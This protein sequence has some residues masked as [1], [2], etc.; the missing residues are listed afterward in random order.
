MQR[1]GEEAAL[2]DLRAAAAARRRREAAAVGGGGNSGG[3][4]QQQRTRL[5]QPP[6]RQG[7]H[8]AILDAE[9][10][11]M[12]QAAALGSCDGGGP[13]LPPEDDDDEDDDG[14]E[15]G[16]ADDGAP[17]PNLHSSLPP[18]W[19]AAAHGNGGGLGGVAYGGALTREDRRDVRLLELAGLCHDLGHGPFSHVFE[20]ELLPRLG[21]AP[22]AWCHEDM[23][24]R[25]LEHLVDANAL[26]LEEDYYGLGAGGGLREV[27]AL[28]RGKE[29]EAE[30][31]AGGRAGPSSSS[32]FFSSSSRGWMFDVVANKRNGIDVDKFDYLVRDAHC[33]G[34]RISTDP[35]RIMHFSRVA[36]Q[37]DAILFK[38]SE[39]EGIYRGLFQ[40]RATMHS[41]VYTHRKAKGLELLMADA[42][43]AAEPVLRLVEAATGGVEGFLAL[44]DGLLRR[45]ERLEREPGAGEHP[46]AVREAK[47]LARRICRRELYA[48]VEEVTVPPEYVEARRKGVVGAAGGGGGG[49]G[50]K[51]ASGHGG[52]SDPGSFRPRP[53]EVADFLP[54]SD[55]LYEQLR[56]EELVLG[57]TRI[58]FT[59]RDA[60]PLDNVQFY[61]GGGGGAGGSWFGGGGG[62]GGG[63]GGAGGGNGGNGSFGGA[64][65]FEISARYVSSLFGSAR[66]C[67]HKIRLYCKRRFKSEGER[68]AC[69]D[70]ARHAFRQ[71]AR[72]AMGS[73]ATPP[74]P[75]KL[76]PPVRSGAGAG[77]G[78]GVR[79]AGAGVGLPPR[80]GG[81]GG[82]GGEGGAN[83]G[84]GGGG[85]AGGGGAGPKRRRMLDFAP[86]QQR[87]PPRPPSAAMEDA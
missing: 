39:Y 43:A 3:G 77:G 4:Q 74:T 54:A 33:T 40:E 11:T 65:R 10:W 57:E 19:A 50:G 59:R 78:G 24:E 52:A 6:L 64:G 44:D 7:H 58:D 42:L 79:G 56:P 16:R 2:A 86:T 14:D 81:G 29:E 63:A 32:S 85:G 72:H 84:D 76:L 13:L 82:G 46:G 5:G 1:R 15:Q 35:R 83:G 53:E 22:G 60:N 47:E 66:H 21:L 71:W 51:A 12:S 28:I 61:G 75:F 20:N 23:S 27:C 48:F 45:V 80:A 69:L 38:H 87:T 34:V 62:E 37:G 26:D 30:S 49:G 68:R 18:S 9:P 41:K 25:V 17:A 55:G 36:D 70:A 8:D 31:P 67:D 73:E